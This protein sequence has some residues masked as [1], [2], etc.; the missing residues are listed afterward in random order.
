MVLTTPFTEDIMAKPLSRD[1]RFPTI[2]PYTGSA[3]PKAHL[4]RYRQ[5]L[6]WSAL[7]DIFR[8]SPGYSTMPM[9]ST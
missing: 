1:F 3:D 6:F 9:T 4:N 8:H 5:Y 7:D 2:K